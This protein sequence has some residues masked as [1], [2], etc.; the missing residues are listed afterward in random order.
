MNVLQ[1]F[2]NLYKSFL[3]IP[4]TINDLNKAQRVWLILTTIFLPSA[5]ILSAIGLI[6]FIY[7]EI[8]FGFN[9]LIDTQYIILIL[10][11]YFIGLFFIP[12]IVYWFSSIL[13]WLIKWV[14][15][16]K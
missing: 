6:S 13:V 11:L 15:S 4:S 1:Y 16:A 12:I 7:I 5:Y 9:D 14:N 10:L 8:M 3:R 2:L